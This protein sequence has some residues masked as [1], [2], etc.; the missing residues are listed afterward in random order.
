MLQDSQADQRD[1]Q[2][3]IQMCPVQYNLTM[4]ATSA[5]GQQLFMDRKLTSFN[6]MCA[7]SGVVCG[8]VIERVKTQTCE[9]GKKVKWKESLSK[10]LQVGDEEEKMSHGQKK[11]GKWEYMERETEAKTTGE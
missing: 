4:C 10:Y 3:G 9:R 11:R 1:S 5:E 7:C 8:W 6:E 2:T